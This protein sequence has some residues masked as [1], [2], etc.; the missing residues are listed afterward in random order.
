M[1]CR[2][3][4]LTQ[5]PD[6]QVL[7]L[8]AFIGDATTT[9]AK[10]PHSAEAQKVWLRAEGTRN[11]SLETI[12]LYDG[13]TITQ[14]EAE[15]GL[16]TFLPCQRLLQMTDKSTLT[17]IA[18]VAFDGGDNPDLAQEFPRL[19]LTLLQVESWS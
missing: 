12:I 16:S 5:A 8:A 1:I 11:G 3:R 4:K 10:W 19:V 15:Q 6:D 18:R 14:Q 13:K 2:P 17:L 7:E 9:L